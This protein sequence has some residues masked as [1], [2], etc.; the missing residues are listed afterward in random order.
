MTETRSLL[1]EMVLLCPA[2]LDCGRAR[3]GK[4]PI[5]KKVPATA[6]IEEEQITMSSCRIE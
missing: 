2:E 3:T 1:R 5:S 4:I 6:R